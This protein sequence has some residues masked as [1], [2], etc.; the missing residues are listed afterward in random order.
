MSAG[1]DEQL[2]A[3]VAVDFALALGLGKPALRVD[4]VRLDAVEIVFRLRVDHA[5]DGVSVGLAVHVR[6]APIVRA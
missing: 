6:N 4:E 1:I 3:Q 2:H 5:E